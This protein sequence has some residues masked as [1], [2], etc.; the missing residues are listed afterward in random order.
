MPWILRSDSFFFYLKY[1]LRSFYLLRTCCGPSSRE[2]E[3]C[4]RVS[5]LCSFWACSHR[6]TRH[7]CKNNATFFLVEIRL[8]TVL[9]SKKS[10]TARHVVGI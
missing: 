4:K 7:V 6:Q 9:S 8:L 2:V 5:Q 10:G 1:K 3:A